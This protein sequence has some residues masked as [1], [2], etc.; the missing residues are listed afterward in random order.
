ML[1][2]IA[3]CFALVVSLVLR[4]LGDDF[5][6][7]FGASWPLVQLAVLLVAH[8]AA[9]LASWTVRYQTWSQKLLWLIAIHVHTL[10]FALNWPVYVGIIGTGE[11]SRQLLPTLTAV[12][13][14]ILPSLLMF[15]GP[16]VA[17]L[18]PPRRK[19]PEVVS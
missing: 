8:G 14:V 3:V 12:A 11:V 15:G 9:G 19:Q 4:T 16:I 6:H 1:V 5:R 10:T 17:L 18:N 7:T 2:L 13:L